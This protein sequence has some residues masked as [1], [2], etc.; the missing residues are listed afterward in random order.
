V[1]TLSAAVGSV[2]FQGT[3]LVLLNLLCGGLARVSVGGCIRER[4]SRCPRRSPRCTLPDARVYEVRAAEAKLPSITYTV[5][6][7]LTLPDA[8]TV[9]RSSA[10]RMGARWVVS[11]VNTVT[12]QAVA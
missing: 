5:M 7:G 10:A 4:D 6:P 1:S 9:A 11:I 8:R 12:R 2:P 3:R